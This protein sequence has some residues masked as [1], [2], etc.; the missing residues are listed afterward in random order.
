MVFLVNIKS[1]CHHNPIN[2]KR[3]RE[4]ATSASLK[5]TES[6]AISAKPLVTDGVFMI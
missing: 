4:K 2:E 6:A 5:E 3:A 1:G